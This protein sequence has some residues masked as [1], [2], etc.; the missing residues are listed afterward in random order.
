MK[1]KTFFNIVQTILLFLLLYVSI[2][3]S[4]DLNKIMEDRIARVTKVIHNTTIDNY[5]GDLP[6]TEE[7]KV[8]VVK[9]K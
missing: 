7:T 3:I 2:G 4:R 6:W 8:T 1:N 9:E 5:W